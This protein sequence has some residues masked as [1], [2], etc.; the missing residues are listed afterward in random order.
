M[1]LPGDVALGLR[2]DGEKHTAENHTG[3]G[4][5]VLG[6]QV[7]HRGD[8]QHCGNGHQAERNLNF[9]DV[10]VA[11]HFPLPILRLGEAQYEHGDGLHGEAPDHAESVERGQH[12]YIAKTEEDRQQLQRHDQVNDAVT[13]SVAAM[14]LLKPTGE[15]TVFR[16]AIQNPIRA[17][18]EREVS[19]RPPK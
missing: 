1:A 15:H 7:H 18:D 9:A 17:D 19:V 16:H 3:D 14:R 6:K 12:V 2:E 8:Q 4:G 13:R 10:Q 5:F 11:G